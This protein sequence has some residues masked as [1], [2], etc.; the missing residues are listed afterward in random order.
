MPTQHTRGPWANDP[1]QPTI[2]TDD[3]QTKIA[4][5][6]DLP[7]V[8]GKSDW[9]TEQANAR[10]ISVAPELLQACYAAKETLGEIVALANVNDATRKMLVA[11]GDHLNAAINKATN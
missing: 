6:A 7:W 4:T 3:G 9:M 5:I 2:W 11:I 10:L 8:N 1:L